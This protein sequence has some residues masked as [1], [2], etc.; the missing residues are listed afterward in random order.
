MSKSDFFYAIV[1]ERAWE[2][3][4][5]M[6]RKQDLVRWNMLGSKIADMKEAY[7]QIVNKE[8]TNVPNNV[9][10]KYAPDGETLI[11]LNPDFPLASNDPRVVG[12]QINGWHPVW[13]KDNL[14]A[15]IVQ[16][17]IAHGYDPVK[18][19]YL[20]PLATD[21]INTSNGVLSNDQIP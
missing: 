9:F 17:Q 10:T 21:I 1:N 20:Y 15:Q 16:Q 5:E 14:F 7:R 13:M 12:Y 8:N 19:N 11:I 3:G 2:F 4:G 6:L 18:N